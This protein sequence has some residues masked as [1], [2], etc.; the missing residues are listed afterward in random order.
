MPGVLQRHLVTEEV[1][2]RDLNA[3]YGRFRECR[4]APWLLADFP[5]LYR[6]GSADYFCGHL[7]VPGSGKGCEISAVTARSFAPSARCF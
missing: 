4:S 2:V 6:E 3:M 7:V 1:D 5:W